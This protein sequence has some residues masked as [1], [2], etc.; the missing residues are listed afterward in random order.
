MSNPDSTLPRKR[1]NP[2]S[3][4]YKMHITVNADSRVVLSS[5]IT[6]EVTHDTKIFIERIKSIKS[7]YNLNMVGAMAL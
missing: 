7:D 2:R 1:G 3:L 5:S 4:K 6:T